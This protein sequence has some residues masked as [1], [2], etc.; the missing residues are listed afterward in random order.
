MFEV[1][2]HGAEK[3]VRARRECTRDGVG[4]ERLRVI[5]R[6]AIRLQFAP[7]RRTTG[8]PL[9]VV[10]GRRSEGGNPAAAMKT[11]RTSSTAP[12][13]AIAL[14]TSTSSGSDGWSDGV[15]SSAITM[16]RSA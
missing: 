10:S 5:T 7:E 11:A 13:E 2:V 6:Q 16:R 15:I 8:G 3:L 9:S 14:S 4:D 12:F 1:V